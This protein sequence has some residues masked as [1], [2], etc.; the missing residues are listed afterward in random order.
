MK[1]K[2]IITAILFLIAFSISLTYSTLRNKSKGN[3]IIDSA[4]WSVS[5]AGSNDN[6]EITSGNAE[7][8][9]VITVDN[10]SEVDV[11]YSIKLT[12]LPNDVKV[13]LDNNSYMDVINNE[14]AFEN[15]GT[16]LYGSSPKNHTLTFAAPLDA[17]EITNKDFNINVEFKQKLN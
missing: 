11:L 10:S 15:I 2:L 8:S 14:I 1:N 17:N 5:L 16:L 4:S 3:G 6:I 7:Q 9:Y 13:K 12:D